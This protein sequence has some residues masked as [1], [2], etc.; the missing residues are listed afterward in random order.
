MNGAQNIIELLHSGNY[1]CVIAK[2]NEVRT[3]HHRGIKD[4]FELANNDRGFMRGASIADK[5]I[6]KAAASLIIEGGIQSVY[7]DVISLSALRLLEKFHIPVEFGN[8]VPYIRNHAGNDWC[9]ME[10]LCYEIVSV[11]EILGA[12]RR[13][14]TEKNV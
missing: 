10:K 12:I 3:F 9:P 11:N 8:L 13:F 6:G 5:V 7:A 14:I 1:S 4:L 2:G